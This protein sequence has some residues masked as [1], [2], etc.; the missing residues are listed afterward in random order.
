MVDRLYNTWP[1]EGPHI[2]GTKGEEL[3]DAGTKAGTEKM[4]TIYLWAPVL[5][6]ELLIRGF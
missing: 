5:Q 6:T 2:L 3:R 4:Q 1:A